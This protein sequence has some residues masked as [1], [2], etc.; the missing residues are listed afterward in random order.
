MGLEGCSTARLAELLL[1]VTT[2]L[3]LYSHHMGIRAAA[4]AMAVVASSCWRWSAG[5]GLVWR[6]LGSHTEF[7]RWSSR[8]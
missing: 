5:L 6:I 2:I 7:R 3:I 4:L 8:R 1:R